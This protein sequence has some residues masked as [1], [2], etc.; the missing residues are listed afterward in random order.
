MLYRIF[1]LMVCLSSG[2]LFAQE[3]DSAD[4][5]VQSA[6]TG[7]SSL[8]DSCDINVAREK[9]SILEDSA[10]RLFLASDRE[11]QQ[12][13]LALRMDYKL[14]P[15]SA[16]GT[17]VAAHWM[18]YPSF[19]FSKAVKGN[20][21]VKGDGSD[22]VF[23]VGLVD[24]DGEVWI[25]KDRDIL[26]SA[27]W[28]SFSFSIKDFQLS[29]LGSLGNGKLDLSGIKGVYYVI[30]DIQG[31]KSQ[32]TVKVDNFTFEGAEYPV[33]VVARPEFSLI[34]TGYVDLEY[35]KIT[36]YLPA[37]SSE[38]KK[39][40]LLWALTYLNM[41][42]KTGN[43]LT[44]GVI[45]M[46]ALDFGMAN[47]RYGIANVFQSD[48]TL[49]LYTRQLI[50]H[51]NFVKLGRIGPSL[52]DYVM[53]EPYEFADIG[54]NRGRTG[55]F[56]MGAQAGGKAVGLLNYD[57]Y[58]I[59]LWHDSY[60][61]GGKVWFNFW[62]FNLEGAL[63]NLDYKGLTQK[64]VTHFLSKSVIKDLAWSGR[65]NMTID[66]VFNNG[67]INLTG[68]Y[69]GNQY[70]RNGKI[71]Y[72]VNSELGTMTPIT[73]DDEIVRETY[74]FG[75]IVLAKDSDQ[76]PVFESLETNI[77]KNDTM[78]KA[79]LVLE[80]LFLRNLKVVAD[81]ESIGPSFM[82]MFRNKEVLREVP[83]FSFFNHRTVLTGKMSYKFWRIGL[84]GSYQMFN[85][86]LEDSNFYYFKNGRNITGG[87]TF[88]L[89]L[90]EVGCGAGLLDME[91]VNQVFTKYAGINY[92]AN[93]SIRLLS[94]LVLSGIAGYNVGT[95][96]NDLAT[97]LSDVL[98]ATATLKWNIFKDTIVQADYSM[99][100]PADSNWMNFGSRG[101]NS[102]DPK[103]QIKVL[104]H[105]DFKI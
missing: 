20:I 9:Y 8:I 24:D 68:L 90:V 72:N 11:A 23:G 26:R 51:I 42:Y 67:T 87:L 105:V 94:K 3:G 46:G 88:K 32:G 84:S 19:D 31:K 59:K 64:D 18:I 60:I 104:V 95:S 100:T 35:H 22:N 16:L 53:Y 38:F 37:L 73:D 33:E 27:D 10:S 6:L 58:W 29:T 49:L 36:S 30:E 25:A 62:K 21:W 48:F 97:S 57:T 7:T 103:N 12:G 2:F 41:V 83:T 99:M 81:Y 78:Y 63:N 101:P 28:A 52:N 77:T 75:D 66:N 79:T 39:G 14:D 40:D 55:H 102:Y 5:K 80:D 15:F 96:K 43:L 44:V 82:P 61:G 86:T 76:N 54:N 70:A 92:N 4:G 13:D 34:S 47:D 98:I 91:F 56:F 74:D 89:P 93:L 17:Y 71:Y 50:K 65:L 1:L 45:R 85:S 69:A